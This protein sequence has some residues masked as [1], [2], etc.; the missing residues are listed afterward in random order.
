MMS[1]PAGQQRALNRIGKTLADDDLRL[2]LLFAFFT[3]LAGHEPMPATE[4]VTAP[5]WRRRLMWRAVV[6]VIALSA[7]A[8]AVMLS[9]TLPSRQPCPGTAAAVFAHVQPARTGQQPAC[10]SRQAGQAGLRDR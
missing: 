9:Q 10:A 6:T 7:V 5:R 2:R 4:R 1:L 3:T 8:V